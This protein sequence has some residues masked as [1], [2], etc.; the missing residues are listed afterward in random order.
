MKLIK[1]LICDSS[2]DVSIW[3]TNKG[4]TLYD[5]YYELGLNENIGGYWSEIWLLKLDINYAIVKQIQDPFNIFV[6]ELENELIE[7]EDIICYIATGEQPE[8]RYS[9]VVVNQNFNRNQIK[10]RYGEGIT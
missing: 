10:Q 8:S 4:Y 9:N 6:V 7:K 5:D 1:T 2:F 3:L